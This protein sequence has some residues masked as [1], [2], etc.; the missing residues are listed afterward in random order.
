MSQEKLTLE[1]YPNNLW[2]QTTQHFLK[3]A[4]KMS[5]PNLE[6]NTTINEIFFKNIILNKN[7]FTLQDQADF[8]NNIYQCFHHY[9]FASSL[10]TEKR[11]SLAKKINLNA[12]QDGGYHQ[13]RGSHNSSIYGIWLAF[14]AYQC[15][16]VALQNQSKLIKTIRQFIVHSSGCK[17]ELG[18]KQCSA[19]ATY[20]TVD[21]LE[22]FEQEIPQHLLQWLSSMHLDTGGF[23][24]STTIPVAD[25]FTTYH[26]I[27]VLKKY[28][29]YVI[30]QNDQKFINS[31]LD[32]NKLY[33][34]HN[35]DQPNYE[36]TFYA[37]CTKNLLVK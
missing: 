29:K 28:D 25:L 17:N 5:V 22:T 8:L 14:M 11:F 15:L 24:S 32:K 7:S 4:K 6:T 21:L 33:K 34:N 12:C 18:N 20:A 1:S 16:G 37:Y 27:R 2:E 23:K 26:C 13:A 3:G 35:Y 36:A 31:L 10:T 19:N 30:N 9:Y